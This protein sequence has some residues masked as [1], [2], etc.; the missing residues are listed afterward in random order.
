MSFIYFS[1]WQFWSSIQRHPPGH[2]QPCVIRFVVGLVKPDM[3]WNI[4]ANINS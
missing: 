2:C 3:K 4:E 1:F